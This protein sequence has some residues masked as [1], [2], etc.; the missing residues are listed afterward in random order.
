MKGG[1]PNG[2]K[3]KEHA[4]ENISLGGYYEKTEFFTLGNSN[5]IDTLCPGFRRRYYKGI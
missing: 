4:Q 1:D 3:N 5:G 2:Y